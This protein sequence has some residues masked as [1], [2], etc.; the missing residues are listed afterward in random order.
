MLK[1]NELNLDWFQVK[2]L[3]TNPWIS[4]T[5]KGKPSE[6]RLVSIG[7]LLIGRFL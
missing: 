3:L 5:L 6:S 1:E 7:I 2:S 4:L